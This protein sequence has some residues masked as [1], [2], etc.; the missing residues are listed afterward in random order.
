MLEPF[1]SLCNLNSQ[2]T[3]MQQWLFGVVVTA[4][5]IVIEMAREYGESGHD[6]V[7][8]G[9]SHF[10]SLSSCNRQRALRVLW[11]STVDFQNPKRSG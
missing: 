9:P 6:D 10:L 3:N 11:Y 4:I 8:S 7:V 5:T 1:T 2:L